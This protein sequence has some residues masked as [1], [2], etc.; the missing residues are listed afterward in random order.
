L[1][2][3]LFTNPNGRRGSATVTIPVHELYSILRR[4]LEWVRGDFDPDALCQNFCV[5]IEKQ[6]GTFP[7]IPEL[8]VADE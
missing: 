8:K 7:N 2:Q 6:Q 5:E 1:S 3:Q 4:R